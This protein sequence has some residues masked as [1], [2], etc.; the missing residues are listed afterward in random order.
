MA[1]CDLCNGGSLATRVIHT[2]A[3]FTFLSCQEQVASSSTIHT[4]PFKE[5]FVLMCSLCN[6][7]RI[8]ERL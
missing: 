2:D 7:S 8:H 3:G 6:K 1:T 4:H 5:Q